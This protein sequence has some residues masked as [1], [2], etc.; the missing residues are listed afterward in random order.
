MARK[1]RD[2]PEGD[3]LAEVTCR[4]SAIMLYFFIARSLIP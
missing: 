4:A 1:L 2:L 3:A